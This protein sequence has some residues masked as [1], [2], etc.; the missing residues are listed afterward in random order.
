M[1]AVRLARCP[2]GCIATPVF[3]QQ[4]GAAIQT[5]ILPIL[6]RLTYVLYELHDF[7]ARGRLEH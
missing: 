2:G 4:V 5:F 3:V 1:V 6:K 7:R